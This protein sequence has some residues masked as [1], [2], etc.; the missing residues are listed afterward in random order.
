MASNLL[1]SV[2]NSAPGLPPD[3]LSDMPTELLNLILH[4]IPD[5]DLL[6]LAILCQR[7][8]AVALA[9]HFSRHKVDDL[10]YLHLST[11]AT[12]FHALKG[13]RLSFR[14]HHLYCF[15]CYFSEENLV[16][17]MNEVQRTLVG[18]STVRKVALRFPNTSMS[19]DHFSTSVASLLVH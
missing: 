2:P 15:S 1:R 6:A 9:I 13:V 14:C 19:G 5:E 16:Q 8:N 12:P 11:I 10:R 18:I 3:D 4:L 7:L 17:E